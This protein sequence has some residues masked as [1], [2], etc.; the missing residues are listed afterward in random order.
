MTSKRPFNTSNKP[1]TCLWCGK[2]LQYDSGWCE[3]I[4][5]GVDETPELPEGAVVVRQYTYPYAPAPH[6]VV[7]Y[8]MPD[9]PKGYENN[10]CFCTLTCGYQ[11]GVTLAKLG[12]RLKPPEPE[13]IM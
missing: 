3:E 12:R 7:E 11:F 5:C 10:G 2:K 8:A 6:K 4:E 1:D 9:T 13:E